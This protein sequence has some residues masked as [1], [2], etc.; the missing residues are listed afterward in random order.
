MEDIP[1][2]YECAGDAEWSHC[3][4]ETPSGPNHQLSS[5]GCTQMVEMSD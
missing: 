2:E 5:P 1:D 4:R 3:Q